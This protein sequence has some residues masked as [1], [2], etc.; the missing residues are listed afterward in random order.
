MTTLQ[1]CLDPQCKVC[2]TDEY[3]DKYT[4]EQKCQRQPYCDPSKSCSP[5][6]WLLFIVV[7][8]MTPSTCL[9]DRNFAK[10][11]HHPNVRSI[12]VCKEGFHCS[13]AECITCIPHTKCKPGQEVVSKG[14]TKLLDTLS[15]FIT[16][17]WLC[18]CNLLNLFWLSLF[19]VMT[20]GTQRVGNALKGLILSRW[21]E[22]A[23]YG[24]SMDDPTHLF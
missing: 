2:D 3:Q 9:S 15:P 23:R 20:S 19:Q 24:L 7:P 16:N 8:Y 11:V 21:M 6:D 18:W 10:P 12:C 5:L 13:T 17:N 22:S 4:K 14:L 1:S